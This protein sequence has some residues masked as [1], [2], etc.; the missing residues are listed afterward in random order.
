MTSQLRCSPSHM[1]GQGR[2]PIGAEKSSTHFHEKV[3]Q[4]S[5]PQ[6]DK[7]IAP[8]SLTVGA[9]RQRWGHLSLRVS[10]SFSLLKRF[11][12]FFLGGGGA[13]QHQRLFKD[14]KLNLSS[15]VLD[16]LRGFS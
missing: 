14:T 8:H 10:V 4:T 16:E 2:I 5:F 1:K 11:R 6:H 12:H 15:P 13:F 9:S 7:V 3:D